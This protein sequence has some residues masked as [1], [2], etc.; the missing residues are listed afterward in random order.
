[1]R[2]MT[3]PPSILRTSLL[4]A[5]LGADSHVERV[6]VARVELAPGQRTG[7]HRHPCPVIGWI[8]AGTITF[9]VADGPQVTL[10]AGDAFHEPA[11]VPVP[12]FDNASET[13]PAAFIAAYLLPAGEDRL[14]EML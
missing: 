14:I 2:A 10:T 8:S 6:E 12:H 3:E 1:M 9:Q 7:L 11:G 13:E 5:T 4:G